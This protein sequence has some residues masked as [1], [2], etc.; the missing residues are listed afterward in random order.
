M[1]KKVK[2]LNPCEKYNS[3]NMAFLPQIIKIYHV[4]G[5]R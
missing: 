4:W 2:K 5:V 1:K 3:I